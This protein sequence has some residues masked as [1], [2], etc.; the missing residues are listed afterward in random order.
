MLGRGL[1]WL[2]ADYTLERHEPRLNPCGEVTRKPQGKTG[3]PEPTL[4]G[5]FQSEKDFW[6][7]ERLAVQGLKT[8]NPEPFFYKLRFNLIC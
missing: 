3:K 6:G 2:L 4:L 8:L 1:S 7:K 5:L